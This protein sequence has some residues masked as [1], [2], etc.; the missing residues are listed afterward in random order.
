MA[1]ILDKIKRAA[2][3]AVGAA[4]AD[5]Y[6]V[7]RD[8]KGA[9]GA[10]TNTVKQ[11]LPPPSAPPMVFGIGDGLTPEQ[12]QRADAVI[13]KQVSNQL[14]QE[15]AAKVR[16]DIIPAPVRSLAKSVAPKTYGALHNVVVKDQPL[17]KR[18]SGVV[19]APLRAVQELVVGPAARTAIGLAKDQ[20]ITKNIPIIGTF[21]PEIAKAADVVSKLP[22]NKEL[23]GPEP[24][25]SFSQVV[26]EGG[27]TAEKLTKAMTAGKGYSPTKEKIIAR[28]GKGAGMLAFGGL[29][30]SN[31]DVGLGGAAKKTLTEVA[32]RTAK[33]A[34]ERALKESVPAV[35]RES[36]E[37]V[38]LF[39]GNLGE[40]SEVVSNFKN[41]LKVDGDQRTL[42][43]KL[44][45]GGDV[46]AANVLADAKTALPNSLD[47]FIDTRLKKQGY[48]AVSYKGSMGPDIWQEVRDVNKNVSYTDNKT[49]AEVYSRGRTPKQMPVM[50]RT[51]NGYVFNGSGQVP[52]SSSSIERQATERLG[53]RIPMP[54]EAAPARQTA[55][56]LAQATEKV[57]QA[58]LPPGESS[59]GVPLEKMVDLP[60]TNVKDKVNALD[61]IR[62]PENV[63]KKLGL[64]KEAAL[65]KQKYD[66][67]LRELPIEI[68]RI[69][70]WS[71]RANEPGAEQRLFQYLDGQDVVLVGEEKKVA[72]EIKT[73]LKD[74]A[75]K[76][77]LPESSRI[78]HYITHIF[79][80]DFVAKEFDPDV[81]KLITDKVA[82]SVYDPFLQKR[83]GA[84]GYKE[85]VWQAL[86]AYTKRAVRKVNM[87]VALGPLERAANKLDVDSYKYVESLVSRINM[88]PTAIDNLVDNL[89]K[90]S[91]VGYKLGQRPLSAISRKV[92]QAVY[93]GTLGLN[94]G[95]ALRNLTQG[96]NTYAE[97]GERYTLKGYMDFARSIKD[98]SRELLDTGVLRD[99]FIQDR[100]YNATK[101]FWE[102]T[103][104]GLFAFFEAAEKI[105]R[106]S[107]YFG[108]KAKAL[109]S[110][111]TEAEAVAFAK[112]IV[113]KTQ[114]RF[115]S[116]DTP[117]AL[118][119]D[120]A[121]ILTQFQS[122][123]V[124]QTEFLAGKFKAKEWAGLIRYALGSAVLVAATGNLIGLEPADMIPFSGVVT[125]KTKLGETPPIKAIGAIIGAL[126]NAPDAYGNERT[127]GK[128]IKDV[129]NTLIPFV[130]AGSQLK[131]A[132]GGAKAIIEGGVDVTS[133]K[134]KGY[135]AV[136]TPLE[137][138]KAVLFGPYS[139][140]GPE[141][142]RL[143]EQGDLLKSVKKEEKP[144]AAQELSGKEAGK[145]RQEIQM[146]K[147]NE[148]VK[149]ST[150]ENSAIAL[151][152]RLAADTALDNA[153]KLDLIK[154]LKESDPAAYAKFISI[155][156]DRAKLKKVGPLTYEEEQMKSLG[157]D[158]G[159]RAKFIDAQL[160]ALPKEQRGQKLKSLFEKGVI[161]REVLKQMLKLKGVSPKAE[162]PKKGA[163][164]KG[165]MTLGMLSEKF[166]S[167]G[168]PGT[169]GRDNTGGWSYGAW[170]L[171]H[172]NALKFIN[173]SPY[174]AAFAGIKFNSD[175]WRNK[176]K[177]VAEADPEG[178]KREQMNYIAATHYK[179]VVDRLA[180]TGIDVNALSPA[181]KNVI[182]STAVQHG[183]GSKIVDAAL[184]TAGGDE[185]KAIK[186]IY[187][188]RWNGGKNFS[189]STKDVKASVYNRFFGKAG[190]MNEALNN[191]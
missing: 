61:Y 122:F 171:A 120:I 98:G 99:D 84:Q 104:K 187:A 176:W 39:R 37:G 43:A 92:R 44:A 167:N 109:A 22:W 93:R 60:G 68:N 63:L 48:D 70:E 20:N 148:D 40:V 185:K 15:A 180:S 57:R 191:V 118:Q 130:P 76:L 121:K 81:A 134:R 33:E 41:V 8:V 133:K 94:L 49:L 47:E 101:K 108:A 56:S 142:K 160:N 144:K 125:G 35:T 145:F 156:K 64:E 102:K 67:Y 183:P 150:S 6:G 2:S 129:G 95:S 168:S 53:S 159:S 138:A 182:W 27:D 28:L 189:K 34:I 143:D 163:A 97:L 153:G 147:D 124:K 162:E 32:E 62:T 131:K 12:K 174:A 66:D 9:I 100:T 139:I 4:K 51:A 7:A 116:V 75:E 170:Q 58:V 13:A 136:D 18:A 157:V 79:D 128:K 90:A 119:S 188:M 83:L 135:E 46:E 42:L 77:N 132:F 164:A 146:A 82:G 31:L 69:T 177:S 3:S 11:V 91:P 105:N 103:D 166:E 114:F 117:V 158:S 71:K 175:A 19:E 154:K 86:D 52:A 73:Y 173:K 152:E 107:A 110:G 25:K 165:L 151:D 123:N 36:L 59:L 137:K 45:E 17:L 113:E 38:K 50:E 141:R 127:I 72:D 115:G 140:M 24:V 155:A 96:V 29:E 1:S 10:V 190:E 172:N 78:A 87:D 184:K 80:P 16:T 88:R 111:K 65:L 179:P 30:L 21:S 5:A 149:R 23:V 14:A 112:K 54:Q 55:D 106:G 74:W 169:I 161:T 178:F 85:D 89:I 126:A 186:T 26:K 181:L